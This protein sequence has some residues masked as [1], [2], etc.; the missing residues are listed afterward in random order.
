MSAGEPTAAAYALPPADRKSWLDRSL[1][2][3]TD[4]RAGEGATA[5]LMLFNIFLL[6]ICYSVIKTVREPLI[7]LGGGAEVRSY[8]A[9]GQALVLMG[10]VPLYSWFASRVDRVRLLVGVTLFFIVCIELFAV[11]VSARVPY[12]GVAFFIWVGIFNISLVAQFWSFANDIYSKDAGDRLFP[13]ILIGMTAGAPLGSFISGHLFGLGFTP[14]LIL[15]ISAVL[16][17]ASLLLYLLVNARET[18][19]VVSPQPALAVGGGFGLVFRSPYLRLIALLIVLLNVVNTTGEYVIARLLTAHANELALVNPAF[20][21]Q[22][23]IGAFTG[24]YQFWVNVVAVLLQAFVTSR[25]I[26]RAGLRGALLA[27]PFI[28]LGG[29]AVIAA[30]VTF[31]VVRWIKT[32][33]NATDYSVMNTARQLLWLPTSREEKYKAKQAIDTFFV[34]G[35]DLLSAVVVY[36]GTAIIGMGVGGF[37]FTNVMLTLAW[38]AI[39]LLILRHH[40][41]LASLAT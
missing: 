11:S 31:S 15:Q 27:L 39:A 6:L 23:Y 13:I 7:L 9:A 17:V 28:A 24:D 40:R 36:V 34:R 18:R 25:L 2:L 26:K 29:Y 22:A 35:G 19:R 37:A 14:P 21:K 30:G 33:E 4:V 1:S 3:F 38:I 12:V 10:F 20:N 16:L 32:A 41:Q 5:L 8:T